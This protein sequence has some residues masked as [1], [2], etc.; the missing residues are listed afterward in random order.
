MKQRRGLNLVIT[1]ARLRAGLT[2]AELA[3][4]MCT[5]RSVVTKWEVGIRMPSVTTLE[6]LAEVTGHRLEVRLVPKKI[7]KLKSAKHLF[8]RHL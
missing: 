3:R 4:L 7:S 5:H 6:K 2:Q 8:Q 1:T